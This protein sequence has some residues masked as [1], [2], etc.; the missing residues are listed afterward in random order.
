MPPTPP[1]FDPDK[2][3]RSLIPPSADDA[4]AFVVLVALVAT[5]IFLPAILPAILQPS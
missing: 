5:L 1:R 3:I 4:R 2:L